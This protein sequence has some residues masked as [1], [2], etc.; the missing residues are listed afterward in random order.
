MHF[1]FADLIKMLIKNITNRDFIGEY[2]GKSR[3]NTGS[4]EDFVIFFKLLLY[5]WIM[6]NLFLLLNS[7]WRTRQQKN[8]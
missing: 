4:A 7:F 2:I 3:T 1:Y 6:Y 5:Y 8:E